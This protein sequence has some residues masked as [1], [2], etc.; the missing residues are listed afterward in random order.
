MSE[1]RE[2]QIA[3]MSRNSGGFEGDEGLSG[4]GISSHGSERERNDEEEEDRYKDKETIFMKKR[5]RA[6]CCD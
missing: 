3:R 1:I 2:F 5:N 4:S 6:M